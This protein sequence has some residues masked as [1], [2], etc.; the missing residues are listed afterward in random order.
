MRKKEKMA[1]VLPIFE[2]KSLDG[3][4]EIITAQEIP[5]RKELDAETDNSLAEGDA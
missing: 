5:K 1:S 3:P 4:Y 2:E